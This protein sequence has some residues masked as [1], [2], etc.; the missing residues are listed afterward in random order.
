MSGIMLYPKDLL[1]NKPLGQIVF[2]KII[3]AKDRL[4]WNNFVTAFGRTTLNEIL[5]ILESEGY[6]KILSDEEDVK[7]DDIAVR[8]GLTNLFKEEE[9]QANEVLEYLNTKIT[10]GDT[11]K[12]GFSTK[13]SANKK[14]IN[15][16]LLEGY[17]VDDLKKVIDVMYKEWSGTSYAMYLRPETLFNPTKF[18]G[19]L[20]KADKKDDKGSIFTLSTED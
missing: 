1:I 7:L 8:A 9:S 16:R 5:F 15:A 19:Y 12:R 11:S 13:S 17:S 2:M 18:A 10:G 6:I 3:Y 14:F 4:M 20:V